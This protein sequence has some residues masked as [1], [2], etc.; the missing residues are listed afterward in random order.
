MRAEVQ[1]L[2]RDRK[3]VHDNMKAGAN[4]AESAANRKET[5]E[6]EEIRADR[7]VLQHD[8]YDN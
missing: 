1:E 5:R 4:K 6:D 7:R 3:E 8:L 2:K